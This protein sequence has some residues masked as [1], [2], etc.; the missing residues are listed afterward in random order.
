MDNLHAATLGEGRRSAHPVAYT[1]LTVPF[2]MT[3]GFV[4]VALGF[5]GT[6][7]G[8]VVEQVAMLNAVNLF[9]N[10]W[11]F[12]WA[13]VADRTLSRRRWYVIATTVSALGLFAMSVLPLS[14]RTL[15][16]MAG[17]ILLTSVAST[18]I[19]FAIE[20]LIAHNT[21]PSERGR[22][23][24]WFQAGNLG[25]AGIGGG[26]GLWL[27]QTIPSW[28]A[29]AILAALT[30]ACALPLVSIPDVPRDSGGGNLRESIGHVA[31]DL[32][33][34][35]RSR[36]GM[37][38]GLLCFVPVGTG[39][40]GGV[41]TQ[42]EVASFWGAAEG[43]VALVQGVLSGVVSMVGCLVGGTLCSRLLRPRSGYALFGGL[44]AAS[45]LLMA[46][47]PFTVASYVGFG[48]VYAFITGLCFA[49]FSAF[50]LDAIGEG[51]AATKY[52]GFAAL[53]NAP[54]WYMGLLLAHVETGH[55]PRAMLM[56]ESAFGVLGIALFGLLAW[57]LARRALGA[58][59]P[60]ASQAG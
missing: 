47:A 32:W 13:P 48:L 46:L 41:L 49:A 34:M 18:F 56:T 27:L 42:A 26:L 5:L 54:I 37:L 19:G 39:A 43:E 4:T 35:L 44:M 29:G 3:S 20:G 17:L 38:C 50:V 23:S 55:G 11:K 15:M 7:H 14:P 16:A 12:F 52:N 24:G 51:H 31:H 28:A 53:S 33:V 8:L 10:M 59:A 22:V 6:R 2:G 30:M 25:G 45:T 1:L 9:P 36:E 57:A 21:A 40:A 60:G 58:A